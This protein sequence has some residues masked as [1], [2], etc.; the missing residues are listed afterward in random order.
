MNLFIDTNIFLSFYHLTNDD[1]E[2][3]HKLIVL[4]EKGD[5]I[6][7]LPEQVQ[8]E[9][10]RNREVKISDA[11]KKLKERKAKGIYPAFCKDYSEYETLKKCQ[12]EYDE[13]FAALVNKINDDIS[14]YTLNAD[15][16][17]DELFG[18]AHIIDTTI[19]LIDDARNRVDIGN[20]PGKNGSLGDAMNWGALLQ[21][22]PDEENIYVV[23]DDK[24]Y[25]SVLDDELPKDFLKSEWENSKKSELFVYRRLS[26][27]FKEHYPAIKLASE[28]EKQL[29]INALVKSSNF[30]RTH[31]IVSKLDKVTEFSDS[32]VNEI[33]NA[34]LENNQVNWILDDEDVN[35][36]YSKLLGQHKD[37]IEE[38][39]Y[40]AIKPQVD[41]HKNEEEG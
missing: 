31:S 17:I 7:W 19:E 41:K 15:K 37:V 11:L 33:I 4:L 18:K 8:D 29:Q 26:Q 28:L 6:L 9:F 3:L 21:N 39:N 40:E 5:V 10:I 27:F 35:K 30:S 22:V 23:A 32:Q 38:E 20:P 2:E 1:L 13:T 16:V 12:K 24:D 34:G 25:F 36:F 14:K